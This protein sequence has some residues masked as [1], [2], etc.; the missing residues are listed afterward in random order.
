MTMPFR[1]PFLTVGER[2][3]KNTS[4]PRIKLITQ[5][6]HQFRLNPAKAPSANP[7]GRGYLHWIG[8]IHQSNAIGGASSSTMVVMFVDCCVGGKWY[9]LFLL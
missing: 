2:F 9:L 1:A 4:N 5:L 3:I 6:F 8:Q 7:L